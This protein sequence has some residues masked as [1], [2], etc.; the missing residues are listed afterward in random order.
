MAISLGKNDYWQG[1]PYN[2]TDKP[3]AEGNSDSSQNRS[4]T[5]F[6]QTFDHQ[7]IDAYGTKEPLADQRDKPA[8]TPF[9]TIEPGL[10]AAL[11]Q[12]LVAAPITNTVAATLLPP[13]ASSFASA[14]PVG[15]TPLREELGQ[16]NL[17]KSLP[18][19]R[20]RR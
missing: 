17:P 15:P 2:A 9:A 5:S 7:Y 6:S 8:T 14:A 16:L 20:Q 4:Y 1:Y 18:K 10:S 13:N 12:S 19:K 3:A 11:A